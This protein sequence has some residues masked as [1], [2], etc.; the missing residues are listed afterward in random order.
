MS[1]REQLR[2]RSGVIL[3][4]SSLLTAVTLALGGCAQKAS[5]EIAEM[6]KECM[7]NQSSIT[8]TFTPSHEEKAPKN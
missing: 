4:G 6:S 3:I 5:N 1:K 8:I 7:K 2:A